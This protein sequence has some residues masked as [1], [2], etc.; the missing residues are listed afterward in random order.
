MISDFRFQISD[1]RFLIS[2]FRNSPRALSVFHAEARLQRP[3]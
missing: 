1:F 3:E 2:D